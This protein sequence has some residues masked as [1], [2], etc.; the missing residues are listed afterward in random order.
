MERTDFKLVFTVLV[1]I[2]FDMTFLLSRMKCSCK[3][4]VF[5]FIKIHVPVS[6][7]SW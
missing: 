5:C 1:S 7:D 2:C 3:W 6:Q 4:N